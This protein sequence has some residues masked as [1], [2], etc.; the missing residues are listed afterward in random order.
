M[1]VRAKHGG[2]TFY[3]EVGTLDGRGNEKCEKS[4]SFNVHQPFTEFTLRLINYFLDILIVR[5]FMIYA[6]CY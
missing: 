5:Q 2:V 6:A 3:S 1:Q 4:L